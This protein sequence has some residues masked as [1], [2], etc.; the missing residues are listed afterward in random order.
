M[1]GCCKDMLPCKEAAGRTHP[2][3][4]QESEL[5]IMAMDERVACNFENERETCS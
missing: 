1:I 4:D 3:N 2:G 5:Q